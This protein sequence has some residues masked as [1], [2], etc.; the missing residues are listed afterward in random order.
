MSLQSTEDLPNRF[1]WQ[2]STWEWPRKPLGKA[3]SMLG[4]KILNKLYWYGTYLAWSSYLKAID[5]GLSFTHSFHCCHAS[6]CQ[7]DWKH[8]FPAYFF[9]NHTTIVRDEA[10]FEP[11]TIWSLDNLPRPQPPQ[12]D[13]E[14]GRSPKAE[15]AAE[16]QGFLIVAGFGSA[17]TGFCS[18]IAW[19]QQSFGPLNAQT[20]KTSSATGL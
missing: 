12:S 15:S 5:N 3:K 20:G 4:W 2:R 8:F 17:H 10:G 13:G 18:S 9:P 7:S 14:S 16:Q 11:L 19:C 6:Y 1:Y